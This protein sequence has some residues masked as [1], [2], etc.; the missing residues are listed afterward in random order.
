MIAMP[1]KAETAVEFFKRR[2]GNA[3]DADVMKFL[4]RAQKLGL[5]LKT[6][7]ENRLVWEP[8]EGRIRRVRSGKNATKSARLMLDSHSS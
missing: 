2:A 7:C 6:S 4:R 5:S 8:S 1:G 3:T